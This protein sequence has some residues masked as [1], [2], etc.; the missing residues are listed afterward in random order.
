MVETW[1]S[2]ERNMRGGRRGRGRRGRHVPLIYH[3]AH[4]SH[5]QKGFRIFYNIAK[6]RITISSITIDKTR[7]MSDEVDFKYNLVSI[8]LS[9][10]C[11][12]EQT[13][14]KVFI[15]NI[16]EFSS[17]KAKNAHCHVCYLTEDYLQIAKRIK[18]KLKPINHKKERELKKIL[19]QFRSERLTD[20]HITQA[21]NARLLE[22]FRAQFD[23]RFEIEF[24]KKMPIIRFQFTNLQRG[25]LRTG[26]DLVLCML[27]FC[28]QFKL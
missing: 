10:A 17:E 15:L 18:L 6:P 8:M 22:S 14:R 7:L 3:L 20:D 1:S 21:K 19:R 27:A 23:F 9:L 13:T 11:K 28:H 12:T 16:G 4:T 24:S 25:S 26:V 2:E 5:H